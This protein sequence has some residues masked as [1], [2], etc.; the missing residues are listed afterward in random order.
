MARSLALLNGYM[1]IV[2]LIDNQELPVG[3]LRAE[4]DLCCGPSQER[5]TRQ[6]SSSQ[7]NLLNKAPSPSIMDGP[8][9]IAR[10]IS[11]S[12][13]PDT[14]AYT[15]LEVPRGYVTFPA[16]QDDK[17]ETRLS[18]RDVTSPINQEDYQ[19]SSGSRDFDDFNDESNAFTKTGAIT[20]KSSSSSS[21]GLMAALGLSLDSDDGHLD[22]QADQ[23]L[24]PSLPLRNQPTSGRD[25]V[26]E[27][28]QPE[29][30][31]DGDSSRP[32][33]SHSPSLNDTSSLSSSDNRQRCSTNDKANGEEGNKKPSA[34]K[35]YFPL[36]ASFPPGDEEHTASGKPQRQ[37]SKASLKADGYLPKENMSHAE[38]VNRFLDKLTLDD[39]EHANGE[40][41]I[42]PIGKTVDSV[43]SSDFHDPQ[44]KSAPPKYKIEDKTGADPNIAFDKVSKVPVSSN[45]V[46]GAGKPH[47]YT[48]N[49]LHENLGY[50]AELPTVQTTQPQAQQWAPHPPLN[51]HHPLH[52][53]HKHSQYHS[54]TNMPGLQDM[55]SNMY[56]ILTLA[57]PLRPPSQKQPGINLP[58][59]G[60]LQ[61]QYFY[62]DLP[63]TPYP[64]GQTPYQ[65]VTPTEGNPA[66][67][68]QH[69]YAPP[70]GE[71]NAAAQLVTNSVVMPPNTP[72]F[73]PNSK[74]TTTATQPAHHAASDWGAAGEPLSVA[75]KGGIPSCPPPP[76]VHPTVRMPVTLP[77]PPLPG[78][79]HHLP[80]DSAAASSP[81]VIIPGHFTSQP[82]TAPPQP[83]NPTVQ[84]SPVV[85]NNDGPKDL[86]DML[87]QLGLLKYLDKF[88]EQDVDLQ[89]FLSLTDNDLKELGIK[90][91]GPRKKMTNAIA[92]WHSSAPTAKTNLE[93][94]YADKLEGEMQEMAIQLN[95]AYD[96]EDRLKAQ[97]SQE[98]QLRSV[99]E[100]CLMEERSGWEQACQMLQ[101]TRGKL[102]ALGE[103]QSRLRH[104]QKELRKQFESWAVEIGSSNT[105]NNNSGH[106]GQA[107][108]DFERDGFQSIDCVQPELGTNIDGGNGY[109]QTVPLGSK[110][111]AAAEQMKRSDECLKE[112]MQTLSSLVLNTDHI[113][114]SVQS[115]GNMGKDVT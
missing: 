38:I 48:S 82:I 65:S 5:E 103:Q 34:L 109:K 108:T 42:L 92:R 12:R 79:T 73:S 45:F 104:Y 86:K 44:T 18:Y 80:P 43:K 115:L 69:F 36:D 33:D 61:Q 102:R 41:E 31:V 22:S 77:L 57:G 87:G 51:H 21:G 112:M 106:G 11:R 72:H 83:L 113:L 8:E 16:P 54:N 60:G 24:Q 114:K 110:V 52:N 62:T 81:S 10:M 99:T 88:E 40:S 49:S 98:Q 13:Q 95:Q 107:L 2:S 97:V 19:D 71:Q 68:L 91:F 111:V 47:L 85:A 30:D 70:D 20:I 53:R 74:D 14:G 75:P 9:A 66:A 27:N 89:V 84:Q 23:A 7:A 46:K 56:N 3:R 50:P 1:K 29:Y 96:N 105:I 67:N 93:Q 4:A 39:S 37:R 90:L 100:S 17:K 63:A 32:V 6:R 28:E 58:Y 35:D 78:L 55:N 25:S 15:E 101:T 94:A 59:L 26:T 76:A 64:L